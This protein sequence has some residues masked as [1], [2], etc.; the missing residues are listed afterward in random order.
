LNLG[1]G[2]VLRRG[3]KEIGDDQG[4][5]YY[6]YQPDCLVVSQIVYHKRWD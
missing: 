1:I 2:I 3:I 5:N 4:K 6:H